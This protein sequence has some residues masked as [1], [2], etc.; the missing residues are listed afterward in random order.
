[1]SMRRFRPLACA[2]FA[3]PLFVCCATSR[4]HVNGRLIAKSVEAIKRIGPGC[5]REKATPRITEGIFES[6]DQREEIQK[7]I[8][9]EYYEIV[10]PYD[11]SEERLDFD[12]SAKVKI[13]KDNG[14]PAEVIFGNGY[15][16]NFFF[17]SYSE[18][19]KDSTL[20]TVPYQQVQECKPAEMH[21][22]IRS[23]TPA[24]K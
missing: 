18:Q 9:R 17:K 21:V 6:N 3:I 15:G 20:H 24:G 4:R 11:E 1:M 10:F 12:F 8:G 5:Y 2:M 7:N 19:L 13:W 14:E 22:I 23:V 16:R